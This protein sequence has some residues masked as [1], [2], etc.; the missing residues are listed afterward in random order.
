MF[1]FMVIDF[2]CIISY[3]RSGFRWLVDPSAT[4]GESIRQSFTANVHKAPGVRI[5][6]SA[7]AGASSTDPLGGAPGHNAAPRF[8]TWDEVLN[9]IPMRVTSRR[10][11]VVPRFLAT[12]I[13]FDM[14]LFASIV[15]SVVDMIPL[16]L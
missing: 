7:K 9:S 13:L 2:P 11:Y 14:F 15:R 1:K 10:K 6:P 16:H 12:R 8:Q 5:Y 4:R 3:F